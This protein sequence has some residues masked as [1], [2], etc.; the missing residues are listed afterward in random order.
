MG[1]NSERRY[2]RL[3]RSRFE[4]NGETCK[5]QKSGCFGHGDGF[6]IEANGRPWIN[7]GSVRRAKTRSQEC[8]WM[9]L[10][11]ILDSLMDCP[12]ELIDSISLTIV[13]KERSINKAEERLIIS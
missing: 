6:N 5:R 9:A 12:I 4:D 3:Y 7:T 8:W 10:R 1:T 13:A 2:E 11:G